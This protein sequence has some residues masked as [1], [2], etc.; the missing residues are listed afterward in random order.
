MKIFTRFNRINTVLFFAAFVV[1]FTLHAGTVNLNNSSNDLKIL[2]NSELGFKIDFTFSGFN[3]MDVKT[4]KGIFTRIMVPAYSRHGAF[5]YPELP[6]KSEMIE[7]PVDAEVRITILDYDVKEY[8]LKDL[9]IDY[10]VMPNQPPMPKTGDIAGFVYEKDA[11]KINSFSGEE[12]ATVE[13]L[14]TM[15]GVDIGRLDIMPVQY[16]PVTGMI[17][18][19]E[20]LQIEVAF[21]NADLFKT[22]QNKQIY[23]NHYFSGIYNSLLN[24]LKPEAC[25]RENLTQYPIKYVI[26]SD[27]MFEDQLQPFIEWKIK[28]GFTVIEAYTNDPEVGTTTSQIKEYLQG[29]YENAT[30]E[31]PAPSFVQFVGDIAQVPAFVGQAA[32][33][34]TD[35]YFCEYTDDYFPEVFY[36]R[37]SATNTA[38]LQP[39]IDKTLMYEQYTMPVTTYLDSV[40]MIAG[41]DGTFGPIHGNGQINYGTEN[42][43][44]EAHGIFSHTYLYPESGSNSA[45]IRQNISDGVTFANYTAHG[46]PS[47]WA[48]PSFVV[49]DIPALQNNGKY[50]LLIGNCC[51]TSEYQVGE[52]FGEALLRAVNKGAVGY[53]GASNS[54]YWD[55]D[56]YFGVGVGAIAG[57]PPSYEETTLGS[58]DRAFHDHGE[59]FGEW[60]TTA[61]QM[62][63][64]GNLAVTQG[65]PGSALYYW[66]AY[67]L[68][69]D[70]SFMVYFTE[71]PVMTVNYEP[72]L[73]IGSVT[74]TVNTV[75]YA[76]VGL[77]KDGES[78]GA[79]LA[80]SNGV[81]VVTILGMPEPGN[82]DVVVTAQ[83][84]QPYI[85]TVLMANPEGAY[86][87]LN[88]FLINDINGNFDGLI[89]NGES[90]LMDVE[91]K[92]WGS[93]DA[94]NSSA[95]L[96]TEDVFVSI[97]DE[98]QD[99]GTILSQDSVNLVSAFE[100]QVA[101]SVPDMHTVQFNMDIQG[102]SRESWGSTFSVIIF[103]PA[104]EITNLAID[105]IQGGNGNLRL[106][107]GETVNF[108]V[109]CHNT[110]H[111]D[112]FNLLTVLQSSSPFITF[113]ITECAFDT[114]TWAG[115][116]QATFTGTLAAEID[117]GTIIDLNINLSSDPYSATKLFNLPVGLVMEDFESGGFESFGWEMEGDL[118]WQTTVENVFDGVYSARSGIIG[119]EQNSA[120]FIELNVAINDSIS[121]FRKVSCEDDPTNDDY[122]WLGFFIDEVEIERWDGEFGWAEVSFPVAAGLHTFKW[123]YHKDYSVSSGLDA[124]W[125]DDIIFPAVAPIV[126]LDDNN[127]NAAVDF[128][129]LPNPAQDRAELY[130]N[131]LAGS[132]A[133]VTIYDLS[134]NRVMDMASGQLIAEGYQSVQINTTALSSGMYF[135]VLQTKEYHITKKLIIK[136]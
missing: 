64:A 125:I 89:E 1:S 58:Y 35:L 39:Q 101:D 40:V 33:H 3:T 91:L 22:N 38:Q 27:P 80:D 120:M 73:P 9:G 53:I 34:V 108:I 124:A 29:L 43:F 7:I 13:F 21:E 41:M 75:P 63:F 82:A 14:G 84:Y 81:A 62:V 16:N 45:Q 42:Y 95:T 123:L 30:P 24:S 99:Y 112:A 47:G 117:P 109:D 48:D 57:D 71:P 104:L 83:N 85:G 25:G 19:Y 70:P 93:A 32:S 36:G 11:Y 105:D 77:S 66:E 122:D 87:I 110:G 54:T 121:F 69:G 10:P 20:N 102:E 90:I 111:Y 12:I 114:L 50:G 65:S 67:C 116:K 8:R 134:G 31:D 106:D 18:V 115:M 131:F 135:C 37:F 103:A 118:P 23:G 56:Y 113:G 128:Y 15:R 68:M 98:Y 17:R 61:D 55:E 2:E 51:S 100:F 72:I 129:I 5:G 6:V 126:G 78:L 26:V 94:L 136:R 130:M 132:F 44:N 49:S 96:S 28:K 59:P 92:N 79:A 76:Y 52:C 107:P 4:P 86:V 133:S 46:S 60:Y 88:S 127:E 97:T 74:F 119:H